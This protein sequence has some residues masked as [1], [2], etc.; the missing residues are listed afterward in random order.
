M[1][2]Y[3]SEIYSIIVKKDGE[4]IMDFKKLTEEIIATYLCD[5]TAEVMKVLG[6]I[7]EDFSMIGTGRSEFYKDLKQFVY[8]LKHEIKERDDIKFTVIDCKTNEQKLTD[9]IT[10]VYGTLFIGGKGGEKTGGPLEVRMDTRFS[11]IYLKREDGWKIVHL[12]H[13]VPNLEQ[14]DGEAYP[15][16]LMQEVEK[17]KELALKDE[18]TGLFNYRAFIEDFDIAEKISEWLYLIDI[19]DFKCINDCYGHIAGNR[20][21]KNFAD[22]LLDLTNDKGRVYRLG[23]DEFA[24]ICLHESG[25][26]GAKKLAAKILEK[27]CERAEIYDN[28]AC[29]REVSI[30]IAP[31]DK[32]LCFDETVKRA[33]SALYKCKTD[34]KSGYRFAD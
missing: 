27:V 3:D 4:R 16:T 33:D 24:L 13:S 14:A 18:L 7:D 8:A 30:G 34:G 25:A 22:L 9:D 29:V 20:A 19:D 17:I 5:D 1:K 12:H 10:L 15:K 31:L 6:L 26:A 11:M 32:S 2:A 23:G 21:L 28:C